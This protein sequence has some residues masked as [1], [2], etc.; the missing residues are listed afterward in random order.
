MIITT[1]RETIERSA[2][3]APGEK[4]LI[5]FSG[6]PDS[7]ALLY[8]L[9]ELKEE[10]QCELCAAHLNHGLRG[11][12]ADEDEYWCAAIAGRLG[13]EFRS[14]R[15]DVRTEA[16]KTG[17][18]LE[19]VGRDMRYRFLEEAADH[20]GAARIATAHTRDDQVET[21]LLRLVR[22]GALTGL[23][24]MR[25]VR[26]RLIRPLIDVDSTEVVS[27]LQ[28]R[29][30][31]YRT[32]STNLD[33]RFSRVVIRR[34]VLPKLRR[35]NPSLNRTVAAAAEIIGDEDNLL[36]ELAEAIL[37]EILEKGV[38]PPAIRLEP[39]RELH[40]ALQRRVLRRL[41]LR[42]RGSL[43]ALSLS[44]VE[45]VR[46][47]ALGLG[48]GADID[49][50]WTAVR[51]GG[52]LIIESQPEEST[53]EF[54]YNAEIGKTLRVKEV[55][56][57]YKLRI[58]GTCDGVDIKAL[59]GPTRAFLDADLISESLE[60]RNRLPGDCYRPLG[61]PGRQKL[62]DLFTNA[63]IDPD[64]RRRTVVF[65]SQSRI[66]WV[67]GFRIGDEFRVSERTTRILSIEEVE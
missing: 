38:E 43:R 5:A 1:V 42:M 18:N 26:G 48:P 46:R 64:Q 39:F 21:V 15:V 65:L 30:I 35:L 37:N 67:R 13:V 3:I 53:T 41:F 9:L 51:R 33:E 31:L 62:Q 17:G 14:A 25:A 24:G 6:G 19:E 45:A 49:G 28:E 52:R 36:S 22:G 4:V 40:P 55:D 56:K 32:D 2:M 12:E 8:I 11:R 44:V 27:Y 47:C 20:M 50:V 54:S 63:K 23:R 57:S 61:A 7:T 34:S 66:C 29:G 10:L 16:E 60:V 59:S 58:M